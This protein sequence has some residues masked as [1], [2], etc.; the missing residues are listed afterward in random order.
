MKP[1]LILFW[2][3]GNE[4]TLKRCLSYIPLE[5]SELYD[6]ID[7]NEGAIQANV[8]C[9]RYD[10][11]RTA[12]WDRNSDDYELRRGAEIQAII[13]QYEIVI[14]IHG[15]RSDTGSF[16]LLPRA[17]VGHVLT[18]SL[19]ASNNIVL[20]QSGV[21]KTTWPIV[22]F[23]PLGLE[24]ETG[25][26][27]EKMIEELWKNIETFLKNF[28]SKIPYDELRT[29]MQSKQYFSVVSRLDSWSTAE[30]PKKDFEEVILNQEVY[31]TLL[32]NNSYPTTRCYLMHKVK[33][34]DLLVAPIE[35]L[36]VSVEDIL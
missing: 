36:N 6:T 12:P 2:T 22:Q 4:Y 10:M 16:I 13:G 3:H 11:N 35:S 20:W 29:R 30:I 1:I 24:I 27:G 23:H 8:R 32:T 7:V 28:R 15:T 17:S 26:M 5:L 18:A 34:M 14:D 31:Y 33:S 25:P 19:F 9:L 21:G